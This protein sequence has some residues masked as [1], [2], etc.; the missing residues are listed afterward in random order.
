LHGYKELKKFCCKVYYLSLFEEM[1][2]LKMGDYPSN[3]IVDII[4][5]VGK[6]GNNY[7]AAARL[8]SIRFADRRHSN[9]KVMKRLFDRAEH[10]GTLKRTRTKTGSNEATAVVTSYCYVMLNPQIS[11]RVIERQ[12]NILRSTANRILKTFK[13]HPYH[14]NLTQ[15]LERE[16]FNVEC[17]FVIKSKETLPLWKTC[18]FG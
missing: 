9:R 11:T 1:F 15:Q 18:F 5:I 6:A 12:Y 4:R 14:I 13:F 3:E 16:I 7:F 2:L 8:Y 17:D 10:R